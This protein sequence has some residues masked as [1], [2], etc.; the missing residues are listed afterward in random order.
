V[1]LLVVRVGNHEGRTRVNVK[2]LLLQYRM[3]LKAWVLDLIQDGD[4]QK[5]GR[6][7]NIHK[8]ERCFILG[9]GHSIKE[10]DLRRLAG[11]IVMTQNHF[12]AHEHIRI[13]KP[14]YHVNVPKYQPRGFDDDWR[15]WLRTMDERLPRETI[16][17]FG[18]NTKYLVDELGLF[19][20]RAY[21]M[22]HG[23]S[24]AAVRR[25]PVDITWTIMAVPTV[26]TQCLAIAIYMGFK[27]IYLLGFDLD[28]NC[29]TNDR[30]Q[31][32]FYGNSPITAN[33]FEIGIEAASGP[34][35]MDWVMMWSVWQQCNLLKREAERRGLKI[36]N[37]TRGGLLNMFERCTYEDL[38]S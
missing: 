8:G 6:F 4:L 9:S 20:G 5:N 26:L 2:W 16:L 34:S 14:A 18:K 15:A 13:I 31:V 24:I 35:G 32:R 25:A 30:D 3:H 29:R 28:Q 12:H 33:R 37:A 38:V 1:P 22:K 19:S 36:I 7:K 23:Y 27:E 17:F 11:E 21:Y 10:Q